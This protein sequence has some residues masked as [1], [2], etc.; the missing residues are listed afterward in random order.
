MLTCLI[1]LRSL[2]YTLIRADK[3]FVNLHILLLV[4]QYRLEFARRESQVR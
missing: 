4:I 2:I 3:N 1:T